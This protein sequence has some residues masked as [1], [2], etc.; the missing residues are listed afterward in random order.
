MAV[1]MMMIAQERCIHIGRQYT[2]VSRIWQV[3][4]GLC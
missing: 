4:E 2:H 3:M 1:T